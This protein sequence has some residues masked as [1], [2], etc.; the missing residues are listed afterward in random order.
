MYSKYFYIKNYLNLES[1]KIE[2]PKKIN[3]PIC[4]ICDIL[5]ISEFLSHKII[6]ITY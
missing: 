2:F 3:F 1:Q 4:Q 5:M 6:S